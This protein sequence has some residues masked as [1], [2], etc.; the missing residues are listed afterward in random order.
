MNK[1]EL[2]KSVAEKANI[3][4]SQGGV[5]VNAV[6]DSIMEALKNGDDVTLVGFGTFKVAHRVERRS[7]NPQTGAEVI[8]PATEVPVFKAG[9]VFKDS[10]K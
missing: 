9:K 6:I 1:A 8:V 2:I 7:R 4:V 3:S 10:V 5:V